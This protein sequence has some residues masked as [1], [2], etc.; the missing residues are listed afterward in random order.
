MIGL[1]G[2]YGV[3]DDQALAAKLAVDTLYS[4]FC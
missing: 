2:W 1:F 4:C 3:F